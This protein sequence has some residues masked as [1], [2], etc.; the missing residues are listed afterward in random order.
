MPQNPNFDENLTKLA[1]RTVDQVADLERIEREAI[2]NFSGQVHGLESAL[3]LLRIGHHF[4][5]RVL[6]LV[7]SKRT[8]RKYEDILGIN[9]REYFPEEGPGVSRSMGYTIAKK[10]GNFWKAVSGDVKIDH[11]REIHE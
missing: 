2:A 9:I 4:G 11:R 3:G 6:V 8:L 1:N 7:H 10:L 5:W